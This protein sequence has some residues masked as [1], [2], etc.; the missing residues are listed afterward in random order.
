ADPGV[1][2]DRIRLGVLLPPG[3]EAAAVR[4]DL[5]AYAERLVRAGGIYGRRLELVY[6]ENEAGPAGPAGGAAA[7]GRPAAAPA[8]GPAAAPPAGPAAAPRVGQASAPPVA[9]IATY[10][11]RVERFVA[12]TQPFALVSSWCAGNE[13]D[14]AAMAAELELPVVGALTAA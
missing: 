1:M 4:A 12:Q 7:A 2:T 11:Q 14:L 13:A 3:A 9:E 8:V 10:R 5:D 6:L